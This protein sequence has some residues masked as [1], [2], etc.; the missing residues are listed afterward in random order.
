[1]GDEP[2]PTDPS[3]RVALAVHGYPPELAGGTERHV[4]SFARELSERGHEVLVLAGTLE[5][6]RGRPKTA[7]VDDGIRIVR[8]QRE[9]LHFERWHR[10]YHAGVSDLIRG[11]LARFRADILH[12]H[13]WLRLSSD[14]VRQAHELN[15]PS[16]VTLHDHFAVCPTINRVLP[17]GELCDAEVAKAPCEDCVGGEDFDVPSDLREALGLRLS[18]IGNELRRAR[19]ILALSRDQAARIARVVPGPIAVEPH[20]FV[21]DGRPPRGPRPDSAGS[22]RVLTLGRIGPDKGQDLLLDAVHATECTDAIE[23]HLF[24]QCYEPEF[25]RRLHAMAEPLRVHFRGAYDHQDLAREAFDVCVLPSRVPETHGLVLDEAQALGVPV[26]A[27][28]RGA[29]R[30]RVGEG[31]RVFG[32]GDVASLAELLRRAVHDRRALLRMRAAVPALRDYATHV[33]HVLG[34]YRDVLGGDL[35]VDDAFEVERHERWARRWQEIE[36]ARGR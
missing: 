19:R 13:H 29:Y 22:L 16:V 15:I 25:E 35:D 14:L 33:D 3:L 6:A 32:C 21:V 36:H 20:P 18:D 24:G 1:M 5:C 28:D 10:L 23:V 8:V 26:F 27:S 12:V 30:E 7:I 9:D 2:L 31:G 11:E 4:A 34:V 17:A